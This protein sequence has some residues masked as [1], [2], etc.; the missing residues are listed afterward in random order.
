MPQ[1]LTLLKYF[2]QNIIFAQAFSNIDFAQ[3]NFIKTVTLLKQF[4][5]NFDFVHKHFFAKKRSLWCNVLTKILILLKQF[6]QNLD[7]AQAL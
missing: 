2:H 7:F 1:T 5:Q 4:H 3:N 6:H